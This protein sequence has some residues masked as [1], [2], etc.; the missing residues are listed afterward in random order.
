MITTFGR[1]QRIGTI[2]LGLALALAAA[3]AVV[4]PADRADASGVYYDLPVTVTLSGK[5]VVSQRVRVYDLDLQRP[6][7]YASTD[8]RGAATVKIASSVSRHHFALWVERPV[9][10]PASQPG[11]RTWYGTHRSY[12]GDS[13]GSFTM[14]KNHARVN[15]ALLA[16]VHVNATFSHPA[17]DGS[18][19]TETTAH[20]FISFSRSKPDLVAEYWGFEG[21][22][23]HGVVQSEPVPRDDMSF[24]A[25]VSWPDSSVRPPLRWFGDQWD[26][27]SPH[28][29]LVHLE[30]VSSPVSLSVSAPADGAA[31]ISIAFEQ[32][33]SFPAHVSKGFRLD[34]VDTST[35][36]VVRTQWIGASAYPEPPTTVYGLPPGTYS[37]RVEPYVPEQPYAT[38]WLGGA[39]DEAAA[40][41]FTVDASGLS[42]PLSS[43]DVVHEDG[44][45]LPQLLF[46]WASVRFINGAYIDADYAHVRVGQHLEVETI[47]WST[48]HENGSEQPARVAYQWYRNG[49]AIPGAVHHTYT[50]VAADA[51]HR[52]TVKVTGI[53]DAT[54]LDSIP[55]SAWSAHVDS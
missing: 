6:G 53:G 14:T 50:V 22:G 48:T 9:G 27:S 26:A 24:T 20:D 45:P 17:P 43:F 16:G 49:T 5:P 19:T 41:T 32:V 7:A 34:T 47:A 40:Q 51:A 23:T 39:T 2:A 44:H 52:L 8:G 25:G 37:L 46:D 28:H 21:S 11:V 15:V 38:T 55:A 31:R 1:R 36:A 18:T 33:D 29:G 30:D 12:R 42:M 35:G 4:Q 3:S 10:L 13:A 54:I